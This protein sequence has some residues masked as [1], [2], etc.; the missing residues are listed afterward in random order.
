M[1]LAA[2]ADPE[3]R[4]RALAAGAAGFLEKPL[5]SLEEFQKALL[6]WL[7]GAAGVA[8]SAE[9]PMLRPDRQALRDDLAHAADMLS[10]AGEADRP[11]VAR[12]IRGL[13]RSSHDTGLEHAATLACGDNRACAPL[14]RILADRLKHAAP[15]FAGPHGTRNRPASAPE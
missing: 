8:S 9:A 7:K 14:A 5:E 13:A 6:R 15:V 3:G 12:F 1:L 10:E 4:D 2:S 11:Y